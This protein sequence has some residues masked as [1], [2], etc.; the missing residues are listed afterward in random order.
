MGYR[1]ERMKSPEFAMAAPALFKV[2]NT[3]RQ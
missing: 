1:L 3:T 2:A